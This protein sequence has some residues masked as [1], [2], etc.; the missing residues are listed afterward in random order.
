MKNIKNLNN[1][2][3]PE[4]E[5]ASNSLIEEYNISKSD[6]A[7]ILNARKERKNKII[8]R[9]KTVLFICDL[10]MALSFMSFLIVPACI[11]EAEK[12]GLLKSLV[13]ALTTMFIG[14]I[15][16]TIVNNITDKL[17]KMFKIKRY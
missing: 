14:G 3:I 15:F 1:K 4:N 12:G 9:R 7:Y 16:I 13:V 17:Y 11:L 5:L 8:K 6:I 10:V 2:T